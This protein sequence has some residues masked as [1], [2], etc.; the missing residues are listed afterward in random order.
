MHIPKEGAPVIQISFTTDAVEKLRDITKN[1][2][3]HFVRNKALAL[4]LK[5]QKISHEQ[6]CEI[7]GIA[8]NTLRSYIK[9]FIDGGIESILVLNFNKPESSLEPFKKKLKNT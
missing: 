7:L 6:I 4:L 1:H 2:P 3:H 9:E 8:G 5:S